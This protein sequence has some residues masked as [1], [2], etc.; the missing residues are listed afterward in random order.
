MNS[1]HCDTATTFQRNGGSG[2]VC[3]AGRLQ[4][5]PRSC[6]TEVDKREKRN[7][8]RE[9]MRKEERRETDSS[10]PWCKVQ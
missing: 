3:M 1:L 9:E 10:G 8:R 5:E 2:C 6:D 4:G 7:S